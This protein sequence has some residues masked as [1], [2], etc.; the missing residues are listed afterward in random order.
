M[1][2]LLLFYVCVGIIC[3]I[4]KVACVGGGVCVCAKKKRKKSLIFLDLRNMF[5]V[6]K[7]HSINFNFP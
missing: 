2:F 5:K 4:I 7:I 3:T 6:V 1:A